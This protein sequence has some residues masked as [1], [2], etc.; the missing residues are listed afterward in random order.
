MLMFNGH[1]WYKKRANLYCGKIVVTVLL[2]PGHHFGPKSAQNPRFQYITVIQTPGR[3]ACVVR[4]SLPAMLIFAFCSRSS[5]L[6]IFYFIVFHITAYPEE[7][8]WDGSKA[9]ELLRVSDRLLSAN[10]V[11]IHWVSP[12]A[13]AYQS[14]KDRCNTFIKWYLHIIWQANCSKTTKWK[15]YQYIYYIREQIC[16]KSENQAMDEMQ[17]LSFL[18]CIMAL[19][20]H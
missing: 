10:S 16:Q 7:Y 20:T 1:W 14:T 12:R 13:S 2:A 15:W 3:H 8:G 5:R 4:C 11:P 17:G 19:D 9:K 18:Y 6:Q